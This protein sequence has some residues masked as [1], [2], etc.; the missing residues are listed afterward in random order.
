MMNWAEAVEATLQKNPANNRS[1]AAF[2]GMATD[3]TVEMS[4]HED[5]IHIINIH[6]SPSS[7]RVEP[8][9]A[10]KR[11]PNKHVPDEEIEVDGP[12]EI[13]LSALL[14]YYAKQP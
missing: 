11:I 8:V 12:S 2:S 3:V 9:I 10:D 5:D 1:F 7:V 6:Y 13:V 4:T 14:Y